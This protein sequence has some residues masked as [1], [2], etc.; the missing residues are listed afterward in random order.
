MSKKIKVQPID[1]SEMQLVA[2]AKTRKVI[3]A[4]TAEVEGGVDEQFVL[5]KILPPTGFEFADLSI[6]SQLLLDFHRDEVPVP[7]AVQ[8]SLRQA[9]KRAGGLKH[10]FPNEGMPSEQLPW[11]I[12]FMGRSDFVQM[13][14]SLYDGIVEGMGHR[15]IATSG[16]HK[17]AFPLEGWGQELSEAFSNEYNLNPLQ[18]L[19]IASN[20]YEHLL[21]MP[22]PERVVPS[23]MR[24]CLAHSLSLLQINKD[25]SF[26]IDELRVMRAAIVNTLSDPCFYF[27]VEASL[28]SARSLVGRKARTL[29]NA[30]TVT[31]ASGEVLDWEEQLVSYLERM[32]RDYPWYWTRLP[33]A[34]SEVWIPL[35]WEPLINKS[36][37]I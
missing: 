13:I 26:S 34:K 4:Y 23:N 15:A 18:G 24:Y 22:A 11:A 27:P 12:E 32:R 10:M 9:L 25:N 14:L 2:D 28:G 1:L 35:S 5:V 7:I 16:A 33:N 20:F 8:R 19:Q 17:A 30:K 36:K 6:P 31:L 21:L 3:T 29:A 37:L